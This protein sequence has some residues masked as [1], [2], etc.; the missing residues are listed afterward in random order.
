MLDL[1]GM[2]REHKM[3]VFRENRTSPHAVVA[4]FSA[5]RETVCNGQSLLTRQRNRLMFQC[6]LGGFALLLMASGRYAALLESY[7]T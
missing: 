1:V 3:N 4:P 7:C 5:I 2:P 6:S